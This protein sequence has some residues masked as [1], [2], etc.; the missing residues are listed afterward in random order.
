[1]T[2]TTMLI[3]REKK[4]FKKFHFRTCRNQEH[5]PYNLYAIVYKQSSSKSKRRILRQGI[6][7]G[8]KRR[9]NTQK[10]SYVL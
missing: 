3:D 5:R 4:I 7:G 2:A 10:Y 9:V 1:M 6:N 8:E